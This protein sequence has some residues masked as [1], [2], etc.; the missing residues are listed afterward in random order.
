MRARAR[1]CA[2]A[3][4][5]AAKATL[6]DVVIERRHL[7]TVRG[8]KKRLAYVPAGWSPGVQGGGSRMNVFS[9][10]WSTS[11]SSVQLFFSACGHALP[12][13]TRARQFSLTHTVSPIVA[14]QQELGR[15][16]SLSLRAC[17]RACAH[18]RRLIQTNDVV[19]AAAAADV[20]AAAAAPPPPPTRPEEVATAEKEMPLRLQTTISKKK[21]RNLFTNANF[22]KRK[23]VK[24]LFCKVKA[25]IFALRETNNPSGSVQICLCKRVLR[26]RRGGGKYN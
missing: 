20:V 9:P 15:H 16:L 23:K 11:R 26:N 25:S 12:S 19:G 24:K 2:R 17:V 8:T 13:V 21:T 1:A 5:L 6:I 4:K 14:K 3:A 18:K 10:V 7:S 22:R